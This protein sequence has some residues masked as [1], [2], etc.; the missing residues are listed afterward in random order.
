MKAKLKFPI[1]SFSPRNN[2]VYV[3]WKAN[4]Y[5]TTDMKWFKRNKRKKDIVQRNV[6]LKQLYPKRF[7]KFCIGQLKLGIGEINLQLHVFDKP[8]S[9]VSKWGV[10]NKD[11]NVFV[12]E[13]S[14]NVIQKLNIY[15]WQNC[16]MGL[17]D[18]EIQEYDNHIIHLLFKGES[19]QIELE[20]EFGLI[21]QKC[22][23]YII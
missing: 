18:C 6:V 23:T 16:N 4:D 11:Y 20:T 22:G 8:I 10:W 1:F 3:C 13:I 9:E 14:D 7:E 19:W 5:K 15:N 17:C 2:M 21:F 12:I